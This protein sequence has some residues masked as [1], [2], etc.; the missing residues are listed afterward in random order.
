LTDKTPIYCISGLGANRSVFANIA[1]PDAELHF[2]DWLEPEKNETL[3]AYAFR[4]SEK[5]TH[6]HPVVLGV[7]FGGIVAQEIAKQR[8]IAH[9]ILISTICDPEE[10]PAT[11]AAFRKAPVYKAL[12]DAVLM[13]LLLQ[14]IQQFGHLSKKLVQY[15]REM[16]AEQSPNYYRWAFSKILNWK[17]A[18]SQVPTLRLHG[19]EDKLFPIEKLKTPNKAIA[20]THLII[21]TKGRLLSELIS[22]YLSST[23]ITREAL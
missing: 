20:G 14:G 17:G 2:L 18:T 13:P 6:E 19:T 16:I 4:M 5:I 12:P 7:S 11:L 9:L 10:L 15:F 1:I 21:Y 23:E 3:S 8:S 22:N